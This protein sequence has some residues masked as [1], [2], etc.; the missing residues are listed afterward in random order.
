[1]KKR[2]AALVLACMMMLPVGSVPVYGAEKTVPL[3]VAETVKEDA[4]GIV[5][6]N[7]AAVASGTTEDGGEESLILDTSRKEVSVSANEEE[8]EASVTDYGEETSDSVSGNEEKAEASVSG[9]EEEAET[10]VTGNEA[11]PSDEKEEDREEEYQ[12][13]PGFSEHDG[14]FWYEEDELNEDGMFVCED[15]DGNEMVLDPLDP[16][17]PAFYESLKKQK[18]EEELTLDSEAL[19]AGAG[20]IYYGLNGAP[21][22][23]P[24][25]ADGRPVMNGVDVSYAQGTINWAAMK[26]AGVDFAIIRAGARGYG[27]AGSLI[28]DTQ[29]AANIQ[30]AAAAGVKVGIY[31]FSQ[32]INEAEAVQE[33][34]HCYSLINGYKGAISLPVYIDYEYVPGGRLALARLSAAQHTL[35]CNAFCAQMNAYGYSSG[36]YANKDMFI[37][38]MVLSAIPAAYSI[39]M[40]NWVQ[41]TGYTGRLDCWQYT[42]GG[43]AKL[44]GCFSSPSKTLDLDFGYFGAS[45]S[46]SVKASSDKEVLLIDEVAGTVESATLTAKVTPAAAKVTWKIIEGES[47]A[48]LSAAEGTSVILQP[49]A[50]APVGTV[51]I[52]A[53]ATNGSAKA[54][55]D[56]TVDLKWK[57]QDEWISQQISVPVYDG[58]PKTL[59][60][61]YDVLSAADTAAHTRAE[62]L[63]GITAYYREES[64]KTL[65]DV[66]PSSLATYTIQIAGTGKFAGT[67]ERSFKIDPKSI[68][69][70]GSIDFDGFE[71]Q[72]LV[73]DKQSLQVNVRDSSI[74]VVSRRTLH[75]QGVN[76]SAG[77][78]RIISVKNQDGTDEIRVGDQI[79]VVIEGIHNYYGT[80]SS[81]P[82]TTKIEKGH[83]TSGMIRVIPDQPWTGR[84]IEPAVFVE[85]D[86]VLLKESTDGGLTGDYVVSYSNNVNIGK[87]AVVTVKGCNNYG[88][89]AAANFAIVTHPLTE[90]DIFVD[91]V[92]DQMYTGTA[93]KPAVT[94]TLRDLGGTKDQNDEYPI[95]RTLVE[96][97]DFTVTY[98]SNTNVGTGKLVIKGKG[99]FTGTLNGEF[100]INPGNL[101]EKGADGWT[102]ERLAGMQIRVGGKNGTDYWDKDG[103]RD[104]YETPFTT[105]PQ[106]P[107]V[108]ITMNGSK[109]A[110]SNYT[111]TYSDNTDI[112]IA[113]ITVEAKGKNYQGGRVIYFEITGK[114]LSEKT[115]MSYG[116][117]ANKPFTAGGMRPVP[118]IKYNGTALTVG[119]D[120]DIG[121]APIEEGKPGSDAVASDY[122]DTIEEVGSYYAVITGKEEYGYS[123]SY[124]YAKAFKVTQA[125]LTAK[126]VLLR[127]AMIESGGTLSSDLIRVLSGS[128]FLTE[129]ED[130]DLQF[131]SGRTPLQEGDT[132]YAGKYTAEVRGKGNFTGVVK[133]TITAVNPGKKRLLSSDDYEIIFGDGSVD[134]FSYDGGAAIKPTVNVRAR[135]TADLSDVLSTKDFSVTYANNKNVGTAV[136]TVKGRGDF[137][138]T[139]KSTFTI[140]ALDTTDSKNDVTISFSKGSA[141]QY[142]GQVQKPTVVVKAGTKT[143]KNKTDYEVSYENEKST[144][145]GDYMVY[146]DY[147]GNYTGAGGASYRIEKADIN[148]VTIT[149]PKQYYCGTIVHPDIST[150]SFKLGKETVDYENFTTVNPSTQKEAW[151]NDTQIGSNAS[152]VAYVDTTSK[153]FKVGGKKQ[154]YY[155]IEK[156]PVSNTDI[157][158][159]QMVTEGGI[160]E[161]VDASTI[162][163][164][165]TGGAISPKI[166]VVD[167][168][169]GYDTYYPDCLLSNSE[170]SVAYSNN[171]KPG[172]KAAI[173]ITG[174]GNYTGTKTVNFTILGQRIDG[175]IKT[176]DDYYMS[177]SK[178]TLFSDPKSAAAPTLSSDDR[179]KIVDDKTYTYDGTQKKPAVR[180]EYI[181]SLLKQ[182]TDYEVKYYD[183][184]D[185][186]TATVE[187]IG[188]GIYSGTLTEEYRINPVTWEWIKESYDTRKPVVAGIKEDGSTR[189]KWTGDII[190]PKVTVKIAGRTLVKGKDYT[191]TVQNSTRIGK[192][193]MVLTGIGNYEGII[194]EYN[195][196]VVQ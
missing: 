188:K 140:T 162:T 104:F 130:Y 137:Q 134:E 114:N 62:V 166:V 18:D 6:D 195:F 116:S 177:V 88:G 86:G 38:D 163:E 160:T 127:D 122:N 50:N 65:T 192:A 82:Q 3:S 106:K 13:L 34:Q 145:A 170:Y 28:N 49:K 93:L 121:Y 30:G 51:K 60:K 144:D 113:T 141:F 186:G 90:A 95:I 46:V 22:A 74:S 143:L 78:F 172:E 84:E 56:V 173:T 12:E 190:E 164:S 161:L 154:V 167:K 150:W 138:G 103:N 132:V 70:G 35:I 66:E 14:N 72:D 25:G 69:D 61:Y 142:N 15:E 68:L 159:Y 117:I 124:V 133:Q 111:L 26:Q 94:V 2:I 100:S 120:Y 182:G 9:N 180:L 153:N 189:M 23:H 184:T 31:Y 108:E 107:A 47:Y 191:V 89:T 79:S 63:A 10:S 54:T 77:D 58:E 175:K 187:I 185:A 129:G 48:T 149:I 27:A 36:I 19:G 118:V 136:V 81:E 147:K 91:Y 156:H 196:Q 125:K 157:G 32:A 20:E 176:D 92:S 75:K 5:I 105:K 80:L 55:S 193:T 7:A 112:G 169:R 59:V 57:L 52:R 126:S 115:K 21:Y 24:V 73:A 41:A 168:S 43:A 174:K 102:D 45:S 4:A 76:G 67:V 146:V 96:K 131:Y 40:A 64:V 109:V 123:G 178:V 151:S 171:V 44:S 99:N 101:G 87:K 110:A 37:S 158:V 39:W 53:T 83:I 1:M 29:F 152:V 194:L 119:R 179:K 135:G 97:T 155:S 98:S 42:S 33:A 181:G 128:E 148:N 8:A 139:M 16:E 17:F 85:S 11:K 183:N 165:Y 71:V